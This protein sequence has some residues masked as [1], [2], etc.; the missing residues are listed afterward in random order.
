MTGGMQAGCKRDVCG[1]L[2]R[3]VGPG[4]PVL[5]EGWANCLPLLF[6][7]LRQHLAHLVA[8]NS[9]PVCDGGLRVA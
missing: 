7:L 9:K 8:R 4:L 1:M 2:D 6:W 3:C 5:L